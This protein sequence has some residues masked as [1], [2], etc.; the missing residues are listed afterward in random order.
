[1]NGKETHNTN[2]K[3]HTS[4]TLFSSLLRILLLLPTLVPTQRKP[5]PPSSLPFPSSPPSDHLHDH[6][7]D[8][9]EHRSIDERGGGR[10]V[11]ELSRSSESELG[12]R[13][14][15]KE[16]SDGFGGV[17][18][19]KGMEEKIREGESSVGLLESRPRVERK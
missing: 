3:E 7:C 16:G 17:G 10:G 9:D 12:V 13:G 18:V 6:P 8:P 2:R 11:R 5:S 14:E 1:L 19:W 15:V 4:T